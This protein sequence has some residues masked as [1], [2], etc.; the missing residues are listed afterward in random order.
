MNASAAPFLR[1]QR[2][3]LSVAF[4][5]FLVFLIPGHSR[6]DKT[7]PAGPSVVPRPAKVEVGSGSFELGP[8]TRIILDSQSAEA[9]E[10]VYFL[11]D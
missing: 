7:V 11:V 2:T 9:Q 8:Q 1:R 3:L 5:V 10:F 6:A 4:S